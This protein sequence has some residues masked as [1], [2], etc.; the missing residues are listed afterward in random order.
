MVRAPSYFYWLVID[1]PLDLC[2]DLIMTKKQFIALADNIKEHNRC[3]VNNG[4]IPFTSDQIDTL[5]LFCQRQN[6]RFNRDR[7]LGY[8]AGENGPSGGKL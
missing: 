4:D 7:W 8:I 5:A 3:A 2:Y 6:S 1:I